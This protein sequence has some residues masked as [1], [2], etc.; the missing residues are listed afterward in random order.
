MATGYKTPGSGRKKD[1]PYKKTATLAGE[2][3]AAK[4]HRPD[5]AR[6]HAGDHEGCDPCAAVR[7][8]AAR[9]AIHPP[10]GP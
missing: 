10:E 4:S 2:I 8:D 7:V 6:F 9:G 1:T 3:G 5:T